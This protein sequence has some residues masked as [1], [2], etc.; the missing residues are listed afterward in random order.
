MY[1]HNNTEIDY[2]NIA[3]ANA[4]MVK[5]NLDVPVALVTDSGTMS[6]GRENL[7]AEF[8]NSCFEDVILV[9]RNYN[10][11]NSRNYSD[12]SFNV[13]MLQFY[14]CNHWQA[15]DLSPYDE[16]LFIDADYLIMSNALSNCWGSVNDVMINHKIVSPID[17]CEPYSKTIDDFGIRLYWATVVYFRKSSIAEHLFSIV[18]HVQENYSYY[19]DLYC[20][21]S[22][23][24]RNDHAFSIAVHMLNGFAE[25]M[26]AVKELPI[27]ALLMAWDTCDIQSVNNI[28]DIT[29]YAEK[30]SA[31]GTY[32]LTRFKN[33]DIHVLNKWAISR[34][35]NKLID[36][37]RSKT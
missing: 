35:A 19:R 23:M 21:S 5:H 29:L 22:G 34:Y 36:L 6:W 9:D 12:T 32:L 30:V 14:N 16:T 25:E 4:L 1:A 28:N 18:R 3:C 11:A 2:F 17:E 24:F 27:P 37:Y 15:Y 8:V 31:T 7:G 26:P 20:F 10:F 13:K 33:Q